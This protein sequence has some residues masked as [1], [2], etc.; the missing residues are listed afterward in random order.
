MSAPHSATLPM[1]AMLDLKQIQHLLYGLAYAKT[2]ATASQVGYRYDYLFNANESAVTY[3]ENFDQATFRR[4]VREEYKNQISR[5]VQA[6]G[7]MT[8]AE[9]AEWVKKQWEIRQKFF[10]SYQETS[11]ELGALNKKLGDL[12]LV[13]ARLSATALLAAQFALVGL[14]VAP[15]LATAAGASMVGWS[16]MATASGKMALGLGTGIAVAVAQNWS[17]AQKADIVLIGEACTSED[18]KNSSVDGLKSGIPGL[19]DDLLV[20]ALNSQNADLMKIYNQ[21]LER[22][23]RMAKGGKPRAVAKLE[24]FEKADPKVA[25]GGKAVASTAMKGLGYMFSAKS[26]FDASNTFVKQWNG[27]L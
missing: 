10:R 6:T 15:Q 7:R 11:A 12:Q 25:T 20:P 23:R 22:L 13:G 8:P 2:V 4:W 24:N 18:S 14:G 5:M 17:S 27:E 9:F 16:A 19:I 21:D 26:L 3:G 1:V